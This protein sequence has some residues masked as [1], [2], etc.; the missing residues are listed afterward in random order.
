[1]TKPFTIHIPML[2]KKG[3]LEKMNA[4]YEGILGYKRDPE[5]NVLRVPDHRNLA[6]C[7]KYFDLT[8]KSGEKDRGA[9]Y[10]FSLEKNFPSFCL[11]L[12]EKGVRFDMLARTPGFYF[13][14]IMDP[15]GNSIE[16]ISE[17]FEDDLNVNISDWGI[18]QDIG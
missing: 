5:L 15:S 4:F 17:N 3:T 2:R 12:K 14:R 8:G 9:L 11:G 1:M 13:A 16:I 6:V 18:Y 7:F 10:E